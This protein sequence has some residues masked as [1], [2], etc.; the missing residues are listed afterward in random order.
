[1]FVFPRNSADNK[2]LDAAMFRAADV[3]A[4]TGTMNDYSLAVEESGIYES[5]GVENAFVTDGM[6][7]SK[8]MVRTDAASL[9]EKVV[10]GEQIEFPV[11]SKPELWQIISA[12]TPGEL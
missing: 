7:A 10:A 12:A 3:E 6:T 9:K 11:H 5:G 4:W 8:T 2:L 1:M